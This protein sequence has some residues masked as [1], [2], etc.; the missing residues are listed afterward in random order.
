MPQM[1]IGARL[2]CVWVAASGD[3]A[4]GSDDNDT[5]LEWLLVPLQWRLPLGPSLTLPL[6]LLLTLPLTMPLTPSLVRGDS[7]S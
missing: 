3:A 1:A 4:M 6:A 2:S 7:L 5:P